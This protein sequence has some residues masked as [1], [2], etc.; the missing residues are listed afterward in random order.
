MSASLNLQDDL[1]TA[2]CEVT[3]TLGCHH[4]GAV[5]TRAQ[6]SR[7]APPV[8]TPWIPNQMLWEQKGTLDCMCRFSAWVRGTAAPTKPLRFHLK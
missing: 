7:P 4:P 6:A 2:V 8:T 1:F 3:L 5:I